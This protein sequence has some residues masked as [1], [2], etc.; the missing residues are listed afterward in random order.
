[1]QIRQ[2]GCHALLN[3][4]WKIKHH[5]RNDSIHCNAVYKHTQWG[6]HYIAWL[7]HICHTR[8]DGHISKAMCQ[9]GNT[10]AF[11]SYY[12][13]LKLTLQEPIS[14]YP[15]F[16]TVLWFLE[17]NHIRER[18]QAFTLHISKDISRILNTFHRYIFCQTGIM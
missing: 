1:M 5:K 11:H 15:G 9:H 10:S 4:R 16:C 18:S 7:C 13:I 14:L 3:I 8:F 2:N 17:E 6:E 12:W